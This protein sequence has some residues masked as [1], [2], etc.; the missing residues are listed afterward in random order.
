[1][2]P[3]S[4]FATIPMH[5][6]PAHGR[7]SLKLMV[8]PRDCI[9]SEIRENIFSAGNLSQSESNTS[10]LNVLANIEEG[11]K[12]NASDMNPLDNS[13]H[14]SLFMSNDQIRNS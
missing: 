7:R 12:L 10:L 14:A 6:I 1:M 11:K 4:K 13:S 8:W 3:I 5:D 9:P 2:L